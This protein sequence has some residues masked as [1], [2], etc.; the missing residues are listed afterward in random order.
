MEGKRRT[1]LLLAL[2]LMAGIL[3]GCAGV[4]HLKQGNTYLRKG[5]YDQAIADYNEAI[6]LNPKDAHAYFN[7]AIA[8]GKKGNYDQ[9]IADLTEAIRLNPKY[10]QAYINRGIA[11]EYKGEIDKTIADWTEAIRLDPKNTWAYNHRGNAYAG[12]GDYDKAIADHTKI[13]HLDPKSACAYNNR[14]NAYAGKGDWD[15]AIADYTVAIRLSPLFALA[16]NNR[17]NTYYRMGEVAKAIADYNTVIRLDPK[18]EYAYYWLI[19]AAARVSPTAREKALSRL[20]ACVKKAPAKTKWPRP[21]SR[22]YLGEL[23]EAGLLREA[24]GGKT[25]KEVRQ[26]RCEACYYI[27]EVRLQRGDKAGAKALFEKCLAT[28]VTN[29]TEYYNARALLKRLNR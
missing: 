17:G 23:D 5:K 9:A 27:G 22:F 3:F 8:Y 7:R 28:N 18:D 14:G 21:I 10:T 6:R 24:A 2:A 15:K 16:Y 26:R 25:P 1:T 13:I 20:A 4:D 19:D 29:F 12:K 11:Y